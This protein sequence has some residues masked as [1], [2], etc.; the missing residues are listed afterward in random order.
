MIWEP[1]EEVEDEEEVEISV[2]FPSLV[3]ENAPELRVGDFCM[4]VENFS[5][6]RG[7]ETERGIL[8][9]V[10][11]RGM[12]DDADGV[13]FLLLSNIMFSTIHKK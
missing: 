9:W 11:V 3:E 6:G 2:K 8:G 12:G 4:L 1:D 13:A 10:G 5:D 7:G